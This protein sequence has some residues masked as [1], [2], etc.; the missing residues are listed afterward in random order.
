MPTPAATIAVPCLDEDV[1]PPVVAKLAASSALIAFDFGNLPEIDA[2]ETLVSATV[3]VSPAGPTLGSVTTYGFGPD[4]VT[5]ASY[6]CR[7]NCS[8]GT[9]GTE[10]TITCTGTLSGGGVVA[11]AAILRVK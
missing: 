4:G 6:A 8:G 10:Y 2:G 7:F 9:A 5:P 11:A 3:A 1:P